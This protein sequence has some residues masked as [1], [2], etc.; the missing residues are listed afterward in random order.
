MLDLN[1]FADRQAELAAGL[2]DRGISE[3]WIASLT[4]KLAK[5]KQLMQSVE[6]GKAERNRVSQEIAQLKSKAKADPEAAK[7]ADARVLS[8]RTLGDTIKSQEGELS[9]LESELDGQMLT[10]PNLPHATVPKG[11]S[12]DENK[13]VRRSGDARLFDFAPAD[14]VTLGEKLGILDFGRAAKISGARFAVYLGAGARLERALIQLMLDVHTQSH[15]YEEVIPPFL[16]NR[17]ALTGTG[18]LPKFEEDLFKTQLED[19]ELFLIPTAEVPLTN[20]HQDEILEGDKLPIAYTAFTPCFRSEAGSYGRDTRGLIRQHQFQKVEMVRFSRPE[21][22]MDELEKMVGHAESILELLE[23]PYRR[24]LLCTGDMGF[25]SQKTYD[26]E[27]WIPTQEQYREISSC[28]NCGDFQAR[29]A[30]IRYRPTTQDKARL[31]H[32]LNGSGLAVGRTFVAILENHQQEDGSIRI[33]EALHRYL[34]GAKGFTSKGD[35]LFLT[36]R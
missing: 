36:G 9:A 23:L 20:L 22:S 31:V 7:L 11:K 35:Q 2:L 14:H 29:R 30:K 6:A 28:S 32:T 24:M 18:N 5:K 33:P 16:V 10:I 3:E 15:D 27:V 8:M 26:I 25:S 19:R 34:K 1:L 17:A 21:D 4:S 12:A 13:E